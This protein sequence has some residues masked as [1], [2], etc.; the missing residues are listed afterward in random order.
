MATRKRSKS[1]RSAGP[2][3]WAINLGQ[4]ARKRRKQ[5]GLTQRDTAELAGVGIDF[6]YDLERGKPTV[7][8]SALM[9]VLEVLGIDVNFVPRMGAV[10]R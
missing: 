9:Q 6:L 7:R 10:T 2:P 1:M 3:S 5:L 8:L 4:L